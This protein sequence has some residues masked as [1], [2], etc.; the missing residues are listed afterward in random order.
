MEEEQRRAEVRGAARRVGDALD[1]RLEALRR[2]REGAM[3]RQPGVRAPALLLHDTG[4]R[5]ELSMLGLPESNPRFCAP[6]RP[7]SRPAAPCT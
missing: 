5:G 3:G 2:R 1:E 4:K 6:A 7:G